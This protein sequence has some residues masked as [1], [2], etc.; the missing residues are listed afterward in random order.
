[1][2]L[3]AACLLTYPANYCGMLACGRVTLKL[4]LNVPPVYVPAIFSTA[5]APEF[6][7]DAGNVNVAT[8]V[9][10]PGAISPSVCGRGDPL[11]LPR[12]ADVICTFWAVP[13]PL[14]F[15]VMVAV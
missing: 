3:I 8:A 4:E 7:A 10:P 13:V 2:L 6:P 12:V 11:A 1:M 14:F 9:P 5:A 15:T